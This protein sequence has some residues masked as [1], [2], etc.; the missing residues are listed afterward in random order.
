ME[1]VDALHDSLTGSERNLSLRTGCHG[2]HERRKRK[3][4]KGLV[5]DRE[6]GSEREPK[7]HRLIG[8][9]TR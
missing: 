3:M 1:E 9:E 4:R 8:R 2:D 6:G 5:T 7:E